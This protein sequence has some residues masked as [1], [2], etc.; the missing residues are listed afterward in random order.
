ME[1]GG[2]SKP[3]RPPHIIVNPESGRNLLGSMSP[4]SP[5]SSTVGTPGVSRQLA[6]PH[7]SPTAQ[8]SQIPGPGRCSSPA[9]AESSEML[10]PASRARAPRSYQ[11]SS[12][13]N[14]SQSASTMSSRGTSWGSIMSPFD[15]SR[16]PSWTGSDDGIIN[17]QTV[18]QRY[19]IIPSEGLLV[20]PEELEND[21]YLHNP[22]PSD[23]GRERCDI[24]TKR[25][26]LNLGSLFLVAVGIL[27]LFIGYPVL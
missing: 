16:A 2:S 27:V 20:F 22:D 17:M 26:L 21:D 7:R 24:W 13:D 15:D 8:S 11:D 18:S 6:P 14:P 23:R 5:Q 25:G 4:S 9:V 1:S 10:L 3:Q 12:K 19:N